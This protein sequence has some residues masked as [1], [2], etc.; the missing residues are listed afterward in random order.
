MDVINHSIPRHHQAAH[1]E[2]IDLER[3]RA[4]QRHVWPPIVLL[5]MALM[6]CMAAALVVLV[7]TDMLWQ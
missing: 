2:A 7:G 5:V 4:G 1:F 6:R 3:G